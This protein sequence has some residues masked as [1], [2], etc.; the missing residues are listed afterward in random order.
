[1]EGGDGEGLGGNYG[2]FEA[3][4]VEKVTEGF[5]GMCLPMDFGLLG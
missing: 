5:W 4:D 3:K 1:V 2:G